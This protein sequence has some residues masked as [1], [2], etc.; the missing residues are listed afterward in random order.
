MCV[1][2]RKINFSPVPFSFRPPVVI[3]SLLSL[4][5]NY[6]I[7]T[8]LLIVMVYSN[9]VLITIQFPLPLHFPVLLSVYTTNEHLSSL[10]KMHVEERRTPKSHHVQVS[11]SASKNDYSFENAFE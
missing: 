1:K 9:F 2:G 6:N 10:K 8:Q 3:A 5:V 4:G 7:E 11:D